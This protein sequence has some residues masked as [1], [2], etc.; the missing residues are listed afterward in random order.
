VARAKREATVQLLSREA[1]EHLDELLD[2]I[3]PLLVGA[4]PPG[5]YDDE[6]L[7]DL[8]S[9]CSVGLEGV[10][11]Y[12]AGTADESVLDIPR[13]TGRRQVQQDL[14]LEGALRAFR[15]A[16]QVVWE[17]LVARARASGAP[18]GD[19][20]LDGASEVWRIV[21][22]FC[23]ELAQ[24]YRE[25]ESLLRD[26]DERVQA[27]VLG[28][29]LEGRGADPQFARDAN[30]ALGLKA[31]E[32]L[33][34]VVGLAN[35]PEELALDN[36]R[37]RLRVGGFTSVWAT[38]AGAEVGVVALGSRSAGRARQLLAPAVRAR[39]GMS[40]AFTVLADLPRARHLAETAA[41]THGA[42]GVRVL[43]DDLVAG[44]V[45]DAPL[46]AGMVYERTIGKLLAAEGQDGPALLSTLRAFLEAD[47]SLN[48]AA[49][50]SFVHRNTMLYRL[51]KVEK[52]TGL[53]VRA[54][55]DQVLWV[56]ALKEHDA[57]TS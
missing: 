50:R 19:A 37:E 15:A 7:A 24:A 13:Q 16:G 35:S 6:S 46:V 14:P 3:V 4:E 2:A 28:A 42:K 49:A 32:Q 51:N 57:R 25:E 8:R 38:L 29:L 27:A 9:S 20:L 34:C 56:L 23:A 44:L 52:I 31:G 48:A 18:V 17:W 33:V 36:A 26:R 10:L 21:D 55:N 53:S 30:H 1:S 22:L 54:L 5:F 45:V 39:A 47:G 41:R 12:L 40:P 43:E 11:A